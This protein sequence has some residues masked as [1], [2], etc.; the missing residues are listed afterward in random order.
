MGDQDSNLN[1]QY[2]KLLCYRYT[3]PQGV[4]RTINLPHPHHTGQT[5]QNPTAPTTPPL[6]L[7]HQKNRGTAPPRHDL[8]TDLNGQQKDT[9]QINPTLATHLIPNC[10][11]N[12]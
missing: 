6:T 11:L 5:T 12:P 3:I 10:P 1:K 2:Q 4:V 8:P 9:R 7:H